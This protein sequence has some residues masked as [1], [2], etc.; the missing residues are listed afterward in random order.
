MHRVQILLPLRYEEGGAIPRQVLGCVREE[1]TERFG[2]VTAYSRAPA[3]GWWRNASR[4]KRDDLVVLE[5]MAKRLDA[6]WWRRYR[7]HLEKVLR[8]EALVIRAHSIR[9]L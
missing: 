7:R 4:T 8:Q 1:L 6:K 9:L 3:Q 2:G 5:V